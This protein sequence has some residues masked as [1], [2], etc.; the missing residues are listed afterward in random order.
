M[1]CVL[2]MQAV[3]CQR[4]GLTQTHKRLDRRRPAGLQPVLQGAALHVLHDKIRHVLQVT[5]RHKA[6]HVRTRQGLHD[7]VLDF[8]TDDILSTV[9]RSHARNFHGKRKAGMA[10]TF[11]VANPVNMG[12]AAR[13]DAVL[14]RKTIQLGAGLQ[15][16]HRPCSSLSAK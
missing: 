14:D 1:H 9:A 15:Q 8:K 12:H 2:L 16:F 13:M 4:H 5:R 10:G 6:R 11:G 3:R 7:L